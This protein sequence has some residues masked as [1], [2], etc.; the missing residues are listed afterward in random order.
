MKRQVE[1]NK[2]RT[3]KLGLANMMIYKEDRELIRE[4]AKTKGK[5]NADIIRELLE[6]F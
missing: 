2:K 5:T 6:G 3:Q 4:L 1:Y